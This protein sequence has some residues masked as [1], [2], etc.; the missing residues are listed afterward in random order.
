MPIP[1]GLV[2]QPDVVFLDL[3]SP[4][5]PGRVD[6]LSVTP[7]TLW[8]PETAEPNGFFEEALELASRLGTFF[9]GHGVGFDLAG[10]DEAHRV[11]WLERLARD[12]EILG[13]RWYTDHLGSVRPGG[14]AA[15]LPL[16]LPFESF[17]A[18]RVRE[19]LAA[20][21]T[22]FETVGV[23][24]S[25]FYFLLGEALD[26]PVFLDACAS[27]PN[28]GVLLD[29]HNLYTHAVNFGLD[30]EAWLGRLDLGNVLEIHIAG[31]RRS[32]PEWLPDGETRHLD[33]HD[34]GIPEAVWTLAEW[35]IPRCA[36]LRGLTLERMEGT[37]T[38]HDVPALADAL[39]RL[40]AL[41]ARPKLAPPALAPGSL[42]RDADA[43]DAET[44]E[45]LERHLGEVAFSRDPIAAATTAARDPAL[46]SWLR[47]AFA[48]A[49]PAGLRLSNLIVARLRFERLTHGDA[50][51][52][53]DYETD[54]EAFTR[55][56]HAYHHAVPAH[57]SDPAGEARAWRDWLSTDPPL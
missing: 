6:Y 56:F 12:Q 4:V 5:L 48:A 18:A 36:N 57:A 24:N 16:P 31:G 22:I 45:G 28:A 34:D 19:N 47:D 29:L 32:E 33:S 23:E 38:R 42:R 40:R 1:V 17:A 14:R 55:R 2:F 21:G 39:D 10:G 50:G 53:A 11:R 46:P 52:D 51:A 8:R 30:A 49:D 41:G 3:V 15:T 37:V 7:E 25:A 26:E 54:P 35:V 44:W 27:A 43:L 13:M 9:V 20:V